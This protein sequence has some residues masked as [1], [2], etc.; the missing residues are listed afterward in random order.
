MQYRITRV[1]C[2]SGKPI[3]LAMHTRKQFP[4]AVDRLWSEAYAALC[5]NAQ[6]DRPIAWRI[7][8]IVNRITRDVHSATIAIDDYASVTIE[9]IGG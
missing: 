9:R 7:R 3:T 2:I 6:L 1:E 5:A 4:A 8:G